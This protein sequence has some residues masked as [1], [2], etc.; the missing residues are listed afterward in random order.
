MDVGLSSSNSAG[1]Y[2]HNI[3]TTTDIIPGNDASAR[4]EYSTLDN[5]METDGSFGL[6]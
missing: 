6:Q 3:K 4:R 5:K 2:G 1:G